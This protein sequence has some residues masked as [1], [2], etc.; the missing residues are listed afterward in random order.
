MLR[1]SG[2]KSS[3]SSRLGRLLSRITTREARKNLALVVE[4]IRLKSK[5]IKLPSKLNRLLR[6][7][8]R[9][10]LNQIL[11]PKILSFNM[12]TTNSSQLRL[13]SLIP[14]PL[15]LSNNNSINSHLRTSKSTEPLSLTLTLNLPLKPLSNQDLLVATLK[16][17]ETLMM[18]SLAEESKTENENKITATMEIYSE[19]NKYQIYNFI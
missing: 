13:L 12:V 11:K 10:I 6:I 16:P 8:D 3:N 7:L 9:N 17:K 1:R 2:L 14:K 5:P 19:T 18:I 15:M 4:S